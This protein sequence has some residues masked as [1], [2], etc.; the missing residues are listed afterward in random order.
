VRRAEGLEQLP[1]AI[2]PSTGEPQQVGIMPV[3]GK[4]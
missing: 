4:K 1:G 2:G 3:K